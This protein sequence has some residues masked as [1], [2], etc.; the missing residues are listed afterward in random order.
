MCKI[1]VLCFYICS[2][3]SFIM[4]KKPA[5]IDKRIN[6]I[7][8][9]TDKNLGE[10]YEVVKVAPIFARN[11]LFPQSI[12]VLADA[13]NLYAY[14]NKIAKAQEVKVVKSTTYKDLFAKIAQDDGLLFEMKA[15]EKGILYE[16]IDPNHIATA[17]ENKYKSQVPAH[18][19]KMK[20]KLSALGEYTVSFQ[21]DNL[22]KDVRIVIKAESSI[23][24]DTITK[25]TEA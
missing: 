7:L 13:N 17:I 20:K 1:N 11:V 14:K 22:E 18:F 10:K 21:Y 5:R 8:L 15:N 9:E 25:P 23:K 4:P 2:N 12:A 6:V 3:Y 24:V 19:F 16:K